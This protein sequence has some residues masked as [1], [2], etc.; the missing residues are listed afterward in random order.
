MKPILLRIAAACLLPLGLGIS[1]AQAQM[2]ATND[3]NY[4]YSTQTVVHDT[5]LPVSQ[6]VDRYSTEIKAILNGGTVVYDQTFT[7]AFTDPTVQAA[8]QAAEALLAAN[9]ATFGAP[10]LAST[11][12]LLL[13]SDTAN[14]APVTTGTDVWAVTTSYIGDVGGTTLMIGEN[15]SQAFTLLMGQVDYDTLLTTD[16]YQSIDVVTTNTYL[17]TQFWQIDGV[18]APVSSVPDASS[19]GLMLGGSLAAMG[20][21]A[22]RKSPAG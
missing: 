15:R 8:V 17:T 22:R 21:F 18:T 5:Y 9:N 3:T 6:T 4:T 1:A 16:V 20:W 14:S 12:T 7:L 13:S 10:F 19:T 2:T 11:N